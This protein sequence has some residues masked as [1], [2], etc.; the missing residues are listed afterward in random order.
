METYQ[1]DPVLFSLCGLNCG[2]CAMQIGG[3]CPGCKGGT[4][5]P[6]CAVKKCAHSH[7]QI[8]YCFQCT[9]Y[10]CER[11]LS[12]PAYDLIITL[13]HQR[14]DLDKAR[15]IG[16]PA[17]LEEQKERAAFLHLLLDQFQDGRRKTFFCVA[18]NLMEIEDLRDIQ[19]QLMLLCPPDMPVQE[20]S[21]IAVRLLSKKGN[22][23]GLLL[24]LRR[25]PRIKK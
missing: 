7:G 12:E 3:Y 2:L 6:L 10:P 15:R 8:P 9:E 25:K 13:Q 24:K 17:Y 1:Q 5:S 23:R 19:A 14:Q 20:K 4:G 22:E 21:A 18:V 16:I 11:F